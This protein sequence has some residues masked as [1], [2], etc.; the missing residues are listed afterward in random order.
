MRK[1]L[2]APLCVA[3]LLSCSSDPKSPAE[4]VDSSATLDSNDQA[5]LT[6]L[7]ATPT[8]A[9]LSQVSTELAGGDRSAIDAQVVLRDTLSTDSISADSVQQNEVW[10][11]SHTSDGDKHYGALIFPAGAP[12]TLPILLFCHWGDSGVNLASDVGL[13]LRFAKGLTGNFGIV[14]PSFRSES[15]TL[16]TSHSWTSEGTASPWKDDVLDGLR[17]VAAAESLAVTTTGGPHLNADSLRTI[18]F[19]RGGGVALLAALRDPRTARV[20]DYF[21]PTDFFGDYVKNVVRRIMLDSAPDLPGLNDLKTTVIDPLRAGTLNI[22][23]ARLE[24]LRRSPAR[25]ASKLPPVMIHH[26]D[27]D[28]VVD[29]SQSEVLWANLQSQAPAVYAKS[30]YYVYPGAGHSPLPMLGKVGFSVKFLLQGDTATTALARQAIPTLPANFHFV[31]PGF[32]DQ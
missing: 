7:F 26:G 12:D 23:S 1:L 25:F 9:E 8:A 18:G 32:T 17:L 29:I 30:Q 24:L 31:A 6:A 15:I 22:D 19:S 5:L 14:I 2:L 3:L 16:D 4:V 28:T 20:V 11:I 13:L 10:I 27:A 21:G